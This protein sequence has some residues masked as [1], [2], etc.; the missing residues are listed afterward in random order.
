MG[1]I[2]LVVDD[3][4]SVRELLTRILSAEGIQVAAAADGQSAI[5]IF[6]EVRPDLVLLDVN[7]PLLNGLEVCRMIK[8]NPD[9]RLTP[10]VLVTGLSET[11]DRIS[12]LDAGA[13]DFLGKPFDRSELIARIRSLLKIKAYTSELESA[14]SVL[15]A[16]AQSIEG[17]D[18]YTQGHCERLS[19]YAVM[20]GE[21]LNLSQESLVALHRAGIVHDIGK[22]AVPDA[23]LLKPGK[24]DD[25]EWTIM[26]QH[27]LVGERICAP[28]KSFRLVLPIIRHHHEKM[29]GSGY[30]DG[31]RDEQIPLTAR[32]LQTVDVFDALT[33]SRPYRAA[34]SSEE[35]L[36]VMREEIRKGWWDPTIFT[37]ME[38][39]IS[40]G[41]L[42]QS[43]TP[44]L[45]ANLDLHK[46]GSG[47]F[48]VQ[49]HLG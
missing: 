6:W 38:G 45:L 10:V 24:L 14:E 40:S 28:L 27:P 17:R 31:L 19:Q 32:I 47:R 48:P 3:D 7:M 4:E 21:Q 15:F 44:D 12:G 5:R 8:Q 23:I 20:L 18:P 41:G 22:V 34:L 42:G 30:P 9:S 36:A 29:D 33:T 11:S 2:V 37:K 25:R 35:A 13:D 16:L 46:D 49:S 39:L 26:R 1:E 43:E